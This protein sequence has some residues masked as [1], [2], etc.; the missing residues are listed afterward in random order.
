LGR[1]FRD[2]GRVDD[3]V[4]AFRTPLDRWLALERG[5]RHADYQTS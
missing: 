4:F 2:V 5:G 1:R 3:D